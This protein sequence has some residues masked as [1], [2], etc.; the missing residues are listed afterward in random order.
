MDISIIGTGYVGLVTGVGLAAH[1]HSVVCVDINPEIVIQLN[2]DKLPIY[3]KGLDMLFREA[4]T[5]GKFKATAD[6]AETINATEITIVAVGTPNVKGQINLQFIQRAIREIGEILRDKDRYHTVVVKSTILPGTTDSILLPILEKSS[7]KKLGEF[8]LGFNPEFL[9]EGCAVED[10]INPDRIV[11]GSDDEQSKE[12]LRALY[13]DWRVDLIEV[14]T[15]T[16]E[17]IKYANNCLLAT[18]IS[19]VN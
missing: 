2:S 4:R 5:T 15:R 8:G 16:A 9:R 13:S 19:V 18:Q 10:F 12:K 11:L 14:N 3:E 17:L 7:G 1:G 6:I